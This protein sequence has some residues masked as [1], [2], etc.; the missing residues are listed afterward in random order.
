MYPTKNTGSYTY[1]ARRAVSRMNNDTGESLETPSA[2]P[3]GTTTT[4][5]SEVV[6]PQGATDTESPEEVAFNNLKGGTQDRIK[7]LIRERDQAKAELERISQYQNPQSF[8]P[9][10][11]PQ[12]DLSNPQVRTAVEQLSRV[13]VATDDKVDQKIAQSI[14][15]LAY[16]FTMKDLADKYDG[17]NGLPKF[18]RTEYEDYVS[19]NPKYQNYDPEDVYNIMYSEEIMDAKM[20]TVGGRTPQPNSSL[21]PT[22]TQVREEQWTPE[23]I[24][25][26]L[27]ES[28][29]RDWYAKNVQLI[30]KV[31]ASQTPQE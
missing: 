4:E 14:G 24:E 17:A 20:K 1:R 15:Q 18:D 30:N 3:A 16:G 25:Q 12:V 28:D 2:S 6:N 19:R 21:R 11:Q 13:G 26:R 23:A 27:K 31:L 8:N 10:P 22:R 29:G 5:R 7:S 9:T